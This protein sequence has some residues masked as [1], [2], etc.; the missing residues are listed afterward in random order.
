MNTVINWYV[1]NK[2]YIN[3]VKDIVFF[4]GAGATFYGIYKFLRF[5]TQRKMLNKRQ[6]ME[7]D[8]KLYNEIRSKLKDYVD[9]Y[10]ATQ[11]KLRDIGIRLLYMNNYP[12]KLDDDGYS[13]MLYYRFFMEGQPPVGYVSGKGIYVMQ[14]L[15][16]FSQSIYH[17]SKNGKWFIDKKDL[18]FRNYQELQHKQLVKRLPFANIL[19]YDFDSDWAEKGEPVFY[20]RYK[21][22][23][24]K[25]FA[26]E[27]EAISIDDE[28]QLAH[29]VSL[30]KNKRTRR[31]RTRLKAIR[32]RIRSRLVQ[33]KALRAARQ[34]K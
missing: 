25:L 18:S 31:I 13:Q 14:H 15:W 8:S 10:G 6:E 30:D 16:V 12:Y 27:L 24:W 32:T 20:T 7:N 1:R 3:F 22:Y 11:E 17:N 5:L 23:K 28:F 4:L 21:Y 26:D 19:G 2:E 29:K 9:D 33:R 34:G